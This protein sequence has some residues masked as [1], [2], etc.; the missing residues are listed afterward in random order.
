MV[1]A[2]YESMAVLRHRFSTQGL[3]ESWTSF[4]ASQAVALYP[5]ASTV[6]DVLF[7]ETLAI[8]CAPNYQ[9]APHLHSSPPMAEQTQPSCGPRGFNVT[10]SDQGKLDYAAG[11]FSSDV[12][13]ACQQ[14]VPVKCSM[15]SVNGSNGI[16]TPSQGRLAYGS[17]AT[18]TC[19]G[20][21]RV[22]PV[23]YQVFTARTLRRTHK[24]MRVYRYLGRLSVV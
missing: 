2:R 10:C 22:R 8:K 13:P 1:A 3:Q 15:A 12:H 19:H 5:A 18:V 20:G 6:L 11:N 16:K 24:W 4:V 17:S 7:G 9:V 21:Y 14:C 23:D